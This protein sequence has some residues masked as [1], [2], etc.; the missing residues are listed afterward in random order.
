MSILL[1]GIGSNHLPKKFIG[2]F[3]KA[4]I[5]VRFFSK[6]NIGL[7]FR[8]GR[9][10][11]VKLLVADHAR[12]LIG[13]LNVANRYRG[14]EQEA[15]WLDF[16]VYLE[17]VVC[18]RLHN[19]AVKILNRKVFEKLGRKDLSRGGEPKDSV[20]VRIIENDFFNNKLQIRRSYNQAIRK[21]ES[22][23]IIFA[24]Y[25][26]PS[27][28]LL[29]LLQKKVLRG[30]EVKIVLPKKSDVVLYSRAVKY[31]YSRLLGMGIKIY[32]FPATVMHAKV[33]VI[34]NRWCTIGSYNLN[35]LSDLLSIE[36]NVEV[37][38]VSI[39]GPFQQE[40]LSIIERE[41]IEIYPAAYTEG[42]WLR[43]W[44]WRIH[45]YAMLAMFNLIY[46][47]TDKSKNYQIE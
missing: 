5:E 37:A 38:D 39:A 35:D 1:D 34:D 47:L 32:E 18:T 45:Y 8:M 6:I 2:K 46:W 33:A 17:G 4:G 27:L 24:S 14:T 11:H 43:R 41:C 44:I 20:K 29:R 9:R 22:S 7:S 19:F 15:A 10:F 3:T 12:A 23:I 25:F 42:S 40:L 30:V 21:A 13:G 31:F 28:K 26:L 16:A 36:L